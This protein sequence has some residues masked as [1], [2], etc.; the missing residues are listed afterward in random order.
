MVVGVL[1]SSAMMAGTA[2]YFDSL[3]DLALQFTLNNLPETDANVILVTE[4]GP[5]TSEQYD[6]VSSI[7]VER[8]EPLLG[9]RPGASRGP[10]SHRSSQ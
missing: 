2:L 9:G 1:L 7:V 8:M 5:T 4:K 3:R 10:A 6:A